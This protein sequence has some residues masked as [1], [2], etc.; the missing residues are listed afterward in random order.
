MS[1]FEDLIDELKEENLLEETVIESSARNESASDWT[2]KQA[3]SVNDSTAVIT[4]KNDFA[5]STD[6]TESVVQM[7]ENI[8][9]SVE[10]EELAVAMSSPNVPTEPLTFLDEDADLFGD[11]SFVDKSAESDSD[12]LANSNN[13]QVNAEQTDVNQ[14]QTNPAVS[15]TIVTKVNSTVSKTIPSAGFY[16]R[17]ALDEVNGLEMTEHVFSGVER[18][19]IK[20]SPAKFDNHQVKQAL[21]EFLQ[22]AEDVDSP[23]HAQLELDLMKETEEWFSTLLIRDQKFS[24]ANLRFYCENSKPG[25]S[26]QALMSLARFYRNSPYSESVRSKFDLII[27]RLF[28]K[29][30]ANHQRELVFPPQE[31]ITHIQELYADWSS[32]PLY[33]TDD[34]DSELLLMALKFQDFINEAENADNF[35]ELIKKDFFKRLKN[36]KEKTNENFFSPLLATAAIECNVTIG[37]RYIAL[38]ELSRLNTGGLSLTD[39]YGVIHDKS[40]SE[41]TSKTLELLTILK[42]HKSEGRDHST[43]AGITTK[44]DAKAREPKNDEKKLKPKNHFK[45]NKWLIFATLATIIGAVI[46]QFFILPTN[47]SSSKDKISQDVKIVNLENSSLKEYVHSARINEDTLYAIIQ[48]TWTNM[49]A[50]QKENVV[51]IFL[52]AGESKGFQ[53]VHFLDTKGVTVA[54]GSTDKIEIL[55]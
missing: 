27:T 5:E 10:N 46:L 14:T 25:L 20:V 3:F 1:L 43:N 40:I 7:P 29:D 48:P 18:E 9:E 31:L 22:I 6:K 34:E 44:S 38:I 54:N 8:Y 24:V 17:K 16:R 45:A 35:D 4:P 19:I 36:F 53:K 51:G 55:Q 13:E 15:E 33:A 32:V 11:I 37:N 2:E 28:S 30:L 52:K 12:N 21:H 47:L 50:S 49:S 23:N 26:S 39:K 42:Q 41:A